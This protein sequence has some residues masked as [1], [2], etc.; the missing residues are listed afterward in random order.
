MEA[1]VATTHEKNKHAVQPCWYHVYIMY[2]RRSIHVTHHWN[3]IK[4]SANLMWKMCPKNYLH[5]ASFN[6]VFATAWILSYSFEI[7]TTVHS[8]HQICVESY[9][10]LMV[11]DV[12]FVLWIGRKFRF[13]L[14]VRHIN[15]TPIWL[16]T[17]CNFFFHGDIDSE[18]SW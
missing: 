13:S 9:L 10:V 17:M 18:T 7:N 2:I 4:F 6:D 12:W 3:R 14:D 1:A 5:N 11:Y 15:M 8:L 16:Y